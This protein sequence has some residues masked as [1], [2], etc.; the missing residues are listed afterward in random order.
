MGNDVLVDENPPSLADILNTGRS[1][2]Y[3]DPPG[4]ILR[5]WAFSE[6]APKIRPIQ[7]TETF[8]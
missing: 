6:H 1:N 3:A 5:A 7:I 4:S 2:S 8:S